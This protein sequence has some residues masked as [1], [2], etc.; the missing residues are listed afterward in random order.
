MICMWIPFG[1]IPLSFTVDLISKM[2][3]A[4]LALLNKLMFSDF[5]P[6]RIHAFVLRP[7]SIDVSE[8]FK[9]TET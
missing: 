6:F 4:C 2:L 1:K 5:H 7:L 9:C 8:K 3:L